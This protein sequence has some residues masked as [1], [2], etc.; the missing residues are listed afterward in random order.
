VAVGSVFAGL[1]LGLLAAFSRDA[2]DGK[3]REVDEVVA[4][5]GLPVLTTIP[6]RR[7]APRRGRELA[8]VEEPNGAAAD[9]FRALRAPLARLAGER[10][11]R[12]FLF[13][14][15]LPDAPVSDVVA[16]AAIASAQAHRPV[17]VISADLR[18]PQ[19][20]DLLG[21]SRQPGLSDVLAGRTELSDAVATSDDGWIR[22]LPSGSDPQE[23]ID[24]LYAPQMEALLARLASQRVDT[25]LVAGSA[26]TY[27]DSLAL[28]ALVD[29]TILVVP[30]GS[31]SAEDLQRSRSALE[32]AGG[33]VVGSVFEGRSRRTRR[34]RAARPP[35]PGTVGAA[36]ASPWEQPER[37]GDGRPGAGTPDTVNGSPSPDVPVRSGRPEGA[38][39]TPPPDDADRARKTTRSASPRRSAGP[40]R[41]EAQRVSD[42][43]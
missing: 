26:T 39:E 40:K 4:A 29:A 19:L 24:L 11:V 7:A 14:G 30:W 28:A 18:H 35:A 34:T 6:R 3:L 9:G 10:G 17:T 1:C 37:A 25:L 42:P 23:A 36:P 38:M 22:C 33:V 43:A 20:E 16:N 13:T 2:L 27:P 12:T 31:V 21:V 8:T 5:I 15:A 32:D 41:T